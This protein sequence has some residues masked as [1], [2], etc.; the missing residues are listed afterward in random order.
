MA[1]EIG[2]R[3]RKEGDGRGEEESIL[4]GICIVGGAA[5]LGQQTEALIEADGG[6]VAG[7]D[8]ESK[9]ASALGCGPGGDGSEK[10][11][12]DALTAGVD[13]DGHGFDLAAILFPVEK[14]TGGGEAEDLGTDGGDP[15]GAQGS[16]RRSVAKKGGV[17]IGGPARGF[18]AGG[19]D[20]GGSGDVGGLHG[21][22]YG[23][24]AGADFGV[25]AAEVMAVE[26]EGVV[27]GVGAQ[28]RK[29]EAEGIN[30]GGRRDE[31]GERGERENGGLA[32]GDIFA[33]EDGFFLEALA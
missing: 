16:G 7:A 8:F 2:N 13:A 9:G 20:G 32:G 1:V 4:F 26:D 19:G 25:G 29:G 17:V 18:R 23:M 24:R 11:G 22:D 27:E 14:E 31:P 5:A 3:G 33:E 12:A 10:S 15:G 21:P 28:A 30:G 6:G